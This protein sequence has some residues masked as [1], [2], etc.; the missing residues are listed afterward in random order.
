MSSA[1]WVTSP[2]LGSF[3][4]SYNFNLHPLT[5]EFS[6]DVGS[7]V[8]FH[9]GELPL[10]LA[11]SRIGNTLVFSGESTGVTS[12]ITNYFTFRVT[13]PDG[14]IDDRTYNLTITPVIITPSWIGQNPF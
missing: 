1:Q 5:I 3:V 10:G 9:N 8:A 13:D 7:I 6:S 14:T 11:Y 2:D 12:A 4:E